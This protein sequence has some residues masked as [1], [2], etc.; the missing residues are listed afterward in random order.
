[1]ASFDGN[2]GS[3]KLIRLTQINY[4]R[5]PTPIFFYHFTGSDSLM[6]M[7]RTLKKT[8]KHDFDRQAFLDVSEKL[9]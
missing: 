8:A 1:V 5:H 6:V 7:W 3:K 2:L 4:V 9:C